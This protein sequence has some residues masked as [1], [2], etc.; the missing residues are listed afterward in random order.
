MWKI[1]RTPSALTIATIAAITVLPVTATAQNNNTGYPYP[2]SMYNNQSVQYGLNLPQMPMSNGSDE[3]RAAD[4]TTCKSSISGNGPLLDMGVLGNQDFYGSFASGTV[5]GR[6]VVPLGQQPKRIDCSSLYQLEIER[7]Q[8]EIKLVKMGMTGK[9]S[10]AGVADA[11]AK[12]SWQ[13]S[14][15][16]DTPKSKP[17]K[18]GTQAPR[19]E[20]PP[21]QTG[22]TARPQQP[23][24]EPRL[25]TAN[26]LIVPSQ[27]GA[28]S[29]PRPAPVLHALA[30]TSAVSAGNS[31]HARVSSISVV[32]VIHPDSAPDVDKPTRGRVQHSEEDLSWFSMEKNRH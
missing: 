18:L 23:A 31:P 27:L 8:H 30:N 32:K 20:A 14:G 24:L 26:A 19:A 3:I 9:G 11:G 1:S 2:T 6:V 10:G 15:W 22:S 16:A 21:T 29:T 5:Y 17:S 12:N 28:P 4:G 13:N 7:L 25:S